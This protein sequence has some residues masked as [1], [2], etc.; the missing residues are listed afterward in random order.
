MAGLDVWETIFLVDFMV[1]SLRLAKASLQCRFGRRGLPHGALA[2]MERRHA[3]ILWFAATCPFRSVAFWAARAV[4]SE[5]SSYALILGAMGATQYWNSASYSV[6]STALDVTLML[7]IWW[8]ERSTL[9]YRCFL[10][11]IGVPMCLTG[12]QGKLVAS[13][14]ILLRACITAVTSLGWVWDILLEDE[15]EDMALPDLVLVPQ[16][17]PVED[18]FSV[19]QTISIYL[20]APIYIFT[21]RYRFQA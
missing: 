2:K 10:A 4:M 5:K 14:C 11:S 9:S 6:Q 12:F 3:A 18:T 19:V 21:R 7:V 20:T 13:G 15:D 1:L 17:E 16:P 8:Q